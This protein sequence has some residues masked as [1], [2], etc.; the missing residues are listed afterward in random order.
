MKTPSNQQLLELCVEAARAAGLHAL[1]NPHRR[2]EVAQSFDHDVKLVMDSECQRVAESVI[3]SHF[4][5]HAILGEE[6]SIAKACHADSVDHAFEWIIDPIDGTANYARGLPTWCC[7]VAVRRDPANSGAGSEI[8]AGCVFVPVLNECYTATIDGPA[9][10]N[11]EPIHASEI[12]T[13]GKATFFA[14]LTK[15]I[16]SRAI[17]FFT[18]IAPRASKLRIIGSAAIDV[19]HVAC[20]RSDGY[21]EAGLYLWDIAA[22]GL[23]ADRAGAIC[24]AYPR[25]E[26]HGLRFLCTNPHIH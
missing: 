11:G 6:G 5:D 23:I 25:D 20:G 10:C 12:P 16:D 19:C 1:N 7:S 22:A 3:H 26:A 4:P 15:D 24:T 8:L 18:D 9:L 14:G 2:E 21:F 17:D 13:L